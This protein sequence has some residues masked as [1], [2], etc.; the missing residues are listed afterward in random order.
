LSSLEKLGGYDFE[1]IAPGHG[2]VMG[3]GKRV[4][5]L[6]RAHRMARE[7][8]VLSCIAEGATVDE[9][10]PRVYDD[11]PAERHEWAKLTLTAHLIKLEREGRISQKA[12]IFRIRRG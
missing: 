5:E 1:F 9:L 6:L 10:T 12:G 7:N 4:V 2:D 3:R 8:K 11:V